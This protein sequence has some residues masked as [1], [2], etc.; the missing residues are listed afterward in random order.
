MFGIFKGGDTVYTE[1]VLD[2]SYSSLFK[3]IRGHVSIGSVIHIYGWRGYNGLLMFDIQNIFETI[4]AA[5]NLQNGNRHINGIES[6]WSYTKRR[7]VKF[8]GVPRDTFFLHLKE[9]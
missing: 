3:V 1:I 5:M 6:F 4:M 8:N 7:L 9:N 2:T